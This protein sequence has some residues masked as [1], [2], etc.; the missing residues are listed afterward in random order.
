MDESVP[1][2]LTRRRFVLLLCV[3]VFENCSSQFFA[4][5]C[6][7]VLTPSCSRNKTTEVK[8]QIHTSQPSSKI[9]LCSCGMAECHR[10]LVEVRHWSSSTPSRIPYLTQALPR[11]LVLREG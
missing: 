4:Q 3:G 8:S 1:K 5:T 6:S 9:T 2:M 11:M 7:L 10:F